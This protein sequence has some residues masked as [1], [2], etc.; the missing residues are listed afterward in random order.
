MAAVSASATSRA[1]YAEGQRR[2]RRRRRRCD[3]W[4]SP[5]RPQRHA[6]ALVP[7]V[8]GRTSAGRASSSRHV[9]EA[10]VGVPAGRRRCSTRAGRARGHRGD[11]RVV[12]VEHRDAARRRRSASTI[13]PLARAIASWEPN[14]PMCALPTLSTSDDL[15]RR[16]RAGRGD[17]ADVPR[18]PSRARGNSVRRGRRAARSAGRP[19][20]LLNEPNVATVVP[21]SASTWASTSLVLVLPCEPVSATTRAPGSRASDVPG[22]QRRARPPGRRRRRRARPVVARGQHGGRPAVAARSRRSRGRRRAPRRGRRTGR[23]ARRSGCRRRRDRRRCAAVVVHGCAADHVGDLGAA[24]WRSSGDPSCHLLAQHDPVVERVHHAADLLA[25][26]VAL[27]G[28]HDGVA[29]AGQRDRQRDRRAGG[30]RPRAPRRARPGPSRR[31]RAPPPRIAAGSS[32]RGLSSVTTS[33]SASR[34]AISPMIG[35]LPG[36]RSPPAP[37][38]T[39]SRPVGQ[40]TQRRAARRS[41]A[42]GLC[43]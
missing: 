17:V 40:R 15:R 2:P 4:C 39:S 12:G 25:G 36:S 27:A 31:R 42:S 18:P 35:R 32:L 30:R 28:H 5:T 9:L 11:Q 29:G 10:H 34:A 6:A 16:D 23:R 3:A 20:S 22:E 26:L 37:I 7:D 33:T 14:S 19:S 8:P 13:S 43:A 21:A 41:T 24:S 38:T 1:A